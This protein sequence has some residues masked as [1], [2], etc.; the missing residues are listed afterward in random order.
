MA[1]AGHNGDSPKKHEGS[2][3][4][5]LDCIFPVELSSLDNIKGIQSPEDSATVQQK[6]KSNGKK[7]RFKDHFLG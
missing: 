2:V 4:Q 6:K 5:S 1:Y 7:T 3:L